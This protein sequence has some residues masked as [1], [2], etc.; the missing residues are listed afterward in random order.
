MGVTTVKQNTFLLTWKAKKILTFEGL[1]DKDVDF[2]NPVVKSG[3]LPRPLLQGWGLA[4]DSQGNL[5]V[6]DGSNVISVV[7]PIEWKVVRQ[8]PVRIK[9]NTTGSLIINELEVVN[10]KWIF[11]NQYSKNDIF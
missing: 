9:G 4:H 5:Y 2:G 10:D 11:A 6:S 8:I 1:T 7:D 3:E